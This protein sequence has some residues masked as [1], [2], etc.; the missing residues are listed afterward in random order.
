M[1]FSDSYVCAWIRIVVCQTR[2]RAD[3]KFL[4]HHGARGEVPTKV[5]KDGGNRKVPKDGGNRAMKY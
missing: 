1:R 2:T 3:V 4:K 5:P